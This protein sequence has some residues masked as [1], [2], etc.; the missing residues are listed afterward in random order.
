MATAIDRMNVIAMDII[1]QVHIN[2]HKQSFDW[3]KPPFS[4]SSST[5]TK[6]SSSTPLPATTTTTTCFV[7]SSSSSWWGRSIGGNAEGIGWLEI[8][9]YSDR[10]WIKKGR[11]AA[12]VIKKLLS[13]GMILCFH[14]R[15]KLHVTTYEC[16]MYDIGVSTL[17]APG[18]CSC[19][20]STSM[21]SNDMSSR[22]STAP[23]PTSAGLISVLE[24][25]TISRVNQ[26]WLPLTSRPRWSRDRRHHQHRYERGILHHIAPLIGSGMVKESMHIFMMALHPR[27]GEHTHI[28]K[29]FR[30]SS[31][32]DPQVYDAQPLCFRD[33]VIDCPCNLFGW[34]TGL[35]VLFI[36]YKYRCLG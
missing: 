8:V 24:R 5:S 36:K 27:V 31:M 21:Y 18:A 33:N 20:T 15:I 19:C 12:H 34:F 29:H 2:D 32:Y 7:S 13:Y 10:I 22:K 11:R 35:V 30:S 6:P 26:R 1:L 23:W 4:L 9:L 28:Y 17:V 16:D 14:G 25:H 3:N